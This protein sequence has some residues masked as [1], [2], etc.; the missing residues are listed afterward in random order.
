MKTIPF[1]ALFALLILTSSYVSTVIETPS[2][3]EVSVNDFN[4]FRIHRQ[5]NGVALSWAVSIPNV[6]HFIVERS[7][8]GSFFET[9]K[10]VA[11]TGTGTHKY[12]DNIDFGGTFYYRV[13]AVAADEN[14]VQS[15]VESV[16]VVKRK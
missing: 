9:I 8:D 6:S 12:I 3:K 1:V 16:R 4:H 10:E 11:S 15:A 7:W 14:T 5:G 13:T 2:T